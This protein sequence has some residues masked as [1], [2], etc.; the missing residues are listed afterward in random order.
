LVNGEPGHRRTQASRSAATRGALLDAATALFAEK[1][2][3][4]AG[5]E[6]IVARAG[7]TRGALYHHF[8]DKTDLFR[9]VFEATEHRV[10]E[11]VATAAMAGSTPLDQLRL[12]CR[13]Y[14]DTA[15]DPAVSRICVVD[16]PAVLPPDVRAE[17][18]DAS[19]LGMVVEVVQ[20]AVDAGQI[21]PQPVEVLS[22]LL[23]ATVMAASQFVATAEDQ[24]KARADAGTAV[25]NLLDGLARGASR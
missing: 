11:A 4:A 24:A 15:L 16:A 8:A 19:A 3:A 10:M 21:A 23:L 13:A 14:L 12:G 20:A 1:G 22:H 18:T 9:A 6:E 25:D 7:V 17:I 2:F 5:R